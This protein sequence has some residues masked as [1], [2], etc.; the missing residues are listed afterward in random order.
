MKG[1]G[2]PK[3]AHIEIGKK[4]SKTVGQ[5]DEKGT[6]INT[7][8]GLHEAAR[9]MQVS[10]NSIFQAVKNGGKSKGSYWRYIQSEDE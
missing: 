8:Q 3:C 7:Y 1:S 10:P 2:C 4:N 9:A 6:L 5:Y